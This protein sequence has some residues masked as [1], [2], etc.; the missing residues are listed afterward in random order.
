[1]RKKTVASAAEMKQALDKIKDQFEFEYS[2]VMRESMLNCRANLE[3]FTPKDTGW[4]SKHWQLGINHTNNSE[5]PVIVM[6]INNL[7]A[8]DKISHFNNVPYIKRL[9][10]G[11]SMQ[12]PG[13]FTHL[14]LNKTTSQLKVKFDKLSKQKVI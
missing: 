12:R 11:Y 13:G 2:V 6:N 14:A 10:E 1:M 3:L 4:A 8:G 5:E 9:D 7:K